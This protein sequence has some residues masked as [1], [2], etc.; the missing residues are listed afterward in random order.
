MSVSKEAFDDTQHRFYSVAHRGVVK[1]TGEPSVIVHNWKVQSSHRHSYNFSK[2]ETEHVS[3]DP[4]KTVH[5][6]FAASA[7][8]REE[9][10][11]IATSST[12]SRI[13]THS[14]DSLSRLRIEP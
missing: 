3:I 11:T 5:V 8:V 14:N 7:P 13:S 6:N 4:A 10:N 2:M 9:T 1:S 12:T